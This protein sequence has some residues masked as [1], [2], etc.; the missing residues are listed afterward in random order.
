MRNLLLAL[1]LVLTLVACSAKDEGVQQPVPE[2]PPAEAPDTASAEAPPAK[3]SNGPVSTNSV[4]DVVPE[5][6]VGTVQLT[7]GTTMEL[8]EL[9]KLGDYYLYISGKLNGRSSTVVSLTRFRDLQ[10]WSSIV[11]KDP[12]TFVVSNKKGKEWSFEDAALYLG[13]DKPGMYA[14]KTL[15]TR[16]D[17]VPV[18]IPK[19]EIAIITFR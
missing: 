17:V 3:A 4:R 10:K 19:N 9:I 14:F 7:N 18:E 11:F 12:R 1:M 6:A 15:N 2:A 8:T 16:Y 5:G 13:T